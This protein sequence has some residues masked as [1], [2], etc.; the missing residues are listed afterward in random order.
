[1]KHFSFPLVVIF[2]V[3]FFFSCEKE[4][5]TETIILPSNINSNPNS[6]QINKFFEDNLD[7]ATQTINVN[8]SASYQSITSDKGIVYT[9]GSNTFINTLGNPVSGNFTIEL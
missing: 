9:F 8:S 7:E 1:M 6:S 3:L 2:S 5:E 4:T